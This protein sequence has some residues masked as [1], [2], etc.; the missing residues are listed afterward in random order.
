MLYNRL[1]QQHVLIS[2]RIRTVDQSMDTTKTQFND[3]VSFPGATYRNVGE[4]LPLTEAEMTQTPA[5][6][7]TPTQHG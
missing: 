4:G 5:A 7:P 1:S 3:P 2:H 6:S